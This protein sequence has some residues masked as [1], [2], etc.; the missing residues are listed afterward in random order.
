[1]SSVIGSLVLRSQPLVDAVQTLDRGL[2]AE[3]IAMANDV[4][5]H[6]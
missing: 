4:A 2:N 1:M 5:H 3:L 6:T